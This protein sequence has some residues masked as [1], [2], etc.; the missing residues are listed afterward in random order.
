MG[1]LVEKGKEEEDAGRP[2]LTADK[3]S[4]NNTIKAVYTPSGSVGIP[5]TSTAFMCGD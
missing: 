2:A 3:N 5:K 1:Y 4:L